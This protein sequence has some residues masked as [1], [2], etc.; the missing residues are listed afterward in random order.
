[1]GEVKDLKE[2]LEQQVQESKQTHNTP[3]GLNKHG[4]RP[5]TA[6][7]GVKKVADYKDLDRNF[8]M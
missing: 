2:F 6:S 4:Q 5:Q 3:I 8:N 1:M 7:H